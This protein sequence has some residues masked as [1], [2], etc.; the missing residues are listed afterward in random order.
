MGFVGGVGAVQDNG[1]AGRVPVYPLYYQGIPYG[2]Y[3]W[4]SPPFP[5]RG[6]CHFA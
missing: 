5:C 2:H 3:L 1:P 4:N 6:D